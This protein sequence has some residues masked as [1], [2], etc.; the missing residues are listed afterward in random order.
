MQIRQFALFITVFPAALA[1]VIPR[2]ALKPAIPSTED[3]VARQL[4]G[5]TGAPG[6]LLGGAGGLDKITDIAGDAKNKA[7]DA[8]AGAKD[9]VGDAV[10][11]AKDIL[12]GLARRSNEE[13]LAARQ[14]EGLTGAAGGLLGGVGGLDKVTDIAGDAKNKV[15]DAVAGAKDKVGDAV[16]QAKDVLGGLALRSS[17]NEADL[18]ARQLEGLTGAAGGLLGGAGGLDKVTD[19][20]GDAKNKVGDAVAGAKDKVGDAVDQAKDVLGGLARRGAKRNFRSRR[21]G[22]Q[23]R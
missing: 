6:G 8:V 22:V 17:S 15:G 3:L 1:G 20:A 10:D 19:I 18:V 12:G 14:L 2:N 13:D 5:L 16:D 4:E 9:K 11:Q 7:T 21:R 23:T